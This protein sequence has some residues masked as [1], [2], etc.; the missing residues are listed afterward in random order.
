MEDIYINICKILSGYMNENEIE[1]WTPITIS[2]LLLVA[3]K[4]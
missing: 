4:Y 3:T 1:K 2:R